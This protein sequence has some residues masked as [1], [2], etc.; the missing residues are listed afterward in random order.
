MKELE[1]EMSAVSRKDRIDEYSKET[2]SP[3][4]A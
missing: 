4:K 2:V 1:S 3:L